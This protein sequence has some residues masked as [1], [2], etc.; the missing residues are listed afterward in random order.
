MRFVIIFN[1][2]LCMVCVC[3]KKMKETRKGLDH[4]DAVAEMKELERR[5]VA[6]RGL[7]EDMD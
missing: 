4:K 5:S 7:D 6:K 3:M 2:I 1:K